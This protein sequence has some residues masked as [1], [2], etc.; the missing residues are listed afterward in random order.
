[1]MVTGDSISGIDAAKEGWA[2]RAFPADQL[3]AEV[4]KV[5]ERIAGIPP[6]LVQL[7][8]RLVHRQMDHMGLR[9]GI[10][11]GTEMCALGTH[12]QAMADFRA[13][14]AEK[15]LTGALQERDSP[16][17]DYRTTNN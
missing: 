12:T 17:G 7:N 9:A 1:M 13:N 3:E 2:N 10:R 4:L 8:K 5:A 14:I 6:E 15:G 16:F 11:A